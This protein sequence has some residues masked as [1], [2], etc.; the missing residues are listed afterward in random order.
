MSFNSKKISNASL[1][2]DKY[3]SILEKA[4]KQLFG[5]INEPTKE[6]E[7]AGVLD[8]YKKVVKD[9]IGK[10]IKPEEE[11]A[12]NTQAVNNLINFIISLKSSLICLIK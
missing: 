1:V 5:S 6:V 4:N 10:D 8:L 9:I 11:Y 2:I 12:P 3:N 7:Q